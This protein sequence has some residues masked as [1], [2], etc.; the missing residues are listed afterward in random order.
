MSGKRCR[1]IDSDGNTTRRPSEFG[2]CTRSTPLGLRL[3]VWKLASTS[4][5]SAMIFMQCS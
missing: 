4:A 1:K 3:P 5:I 2:I